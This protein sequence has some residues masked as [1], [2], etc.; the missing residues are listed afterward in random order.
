MKWYQMYCQLILLLIKIS[1]CTVYFGLWECILSI[2]HLKHVLL[3]QKKRRKTI[4]SE[5]RIVSPFKCKACEPPPN[6]RSA[7]L[8]T[9]KNECFSITKMLNSKKMFNCN[10]F[11]THFWILW[12]L[13]L[14]YVKID[15]MV[16]DVKLFF[17]AAIFYI[18]LNGK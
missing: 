4:W 14:N 8:D 7:L 18:Y 16:Q 12:G 13:F 9:L 6:L 17:L 3:L 15:Q 5:C 11:H 1:A 10:Y 2:P